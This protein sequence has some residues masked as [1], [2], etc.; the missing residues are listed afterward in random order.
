V[1]VGFVIAMGLLFAVGSWS[2]RAIGRLYD[3]YQAQHPALPTRRELIEE[4]RSDPLAVLGQGFR[5][6]GFRLSY[7]YAPV[8]DE[9]VESLRR[10]ASLATTATFVVFTLFLPIIQACSSLID[11]TQL[12]SDW[13]SLTLFRVLWLVIA[14]VW[15]VRWRIALA[16][17]ASPGWWRLVCVLGIATAVIAYALFL[18]L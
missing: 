18:I 5:A 1:L 12:S 13:P 2:S 7:I 4:R 8:E 15:F 9:R 16:N 10:R 17:P 3:A 6:N 11:G 14:G